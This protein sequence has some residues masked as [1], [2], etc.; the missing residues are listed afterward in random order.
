[1]LSLHLAP[2][3]PRAQQQAGAPPAGTESVVT[4]RRR[5]ET[6]CSPSSLHTQPLQ[7]S[8]V[9]RS[10]SRPSPYLSANRNT[11]IRT[12]Q[13]SCRRL[14]RHR[15]SRRSPSRCRL[16][17][18]SRHRLPC[19][20]SSL[21]HSPK[22]HSSRRQGNWRA[23]QQCHGGPF[24]CHPYRLKGSLWSP[25][26]QWFAFSTAWK[27]WPPA[28]VATSIARTRGADPSQ[29][30][31]FS[32]A[33]FNNGLQGTEWEFSEMRL[34]GGGMGRWI[35]FCPGRETEVS[36]V[37]RLQLPPSM[38]SGRP[39]AFFLRTPRNSLS[40]GIPVRKPVR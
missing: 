36:L 12:A 22:T 16:P 32:A 2:Q 3:M 26:Q 23:T 29:R 21:Q 18:P 35:E 6:Q 20:M 39:R 4:C 11:T 37:P 5:Q 25:P 38:S 30:L 1:M 28:V 17:R 19:S 14:P 15:L 27:C 9:Q 40:P 34:W 10:S 7:W 31:P 33:V 8:A 24:L 13:Q